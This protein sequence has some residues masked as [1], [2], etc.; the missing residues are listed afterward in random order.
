[1]NVSGSILWPDKAHWFNIGFH[2]DPT[3][4]G[5]GANLD[6]L[7]FKDIDILTYDPVDVGF[8]LPIAV[9]VANGNLITNVYFEKHP[10][11]GCCC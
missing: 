8:S 2:G 6:S 10:D 4:P 11:T 3:A 1:M 7:S 9:N 5:G